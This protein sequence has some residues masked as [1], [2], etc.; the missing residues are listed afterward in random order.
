MRISN[1]IQNF[2]FKLLPI[3]RLVSVFEAKNILALARDAGDQ[4]WSGKTSTRRL[5]Q[6][7]FVARFILAFLRSVNR[8]HGFGAGLLETTTY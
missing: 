1:F 6:V 5:V 3:F 7:D 8:F 2:L 4:I